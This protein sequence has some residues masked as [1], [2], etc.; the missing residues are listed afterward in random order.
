MKKTVNFLV[1]IDV[2]EDMPDWKAQNTVTLRNLEGI[3]RL[4]NFFDRYNV[5]PTYL[6]TYPVATDNNGSAVF[7]DIVSSNR[8]EIGAHM[9]T[10]TTPP[11]A[12]EEKDNLLLANCLDDETLNAKLTNIT[13]AIRDRYGFN[14]A[15]YR[16]GRFGFDYRSAFILKK[17]GYKVDTSSTPLM[18]WQYIGGPSC[19]FDS[20]KP[21]MLNEK[22]GNDEL[23]QLLE[24]PVSISLTRELPRFLKHLYLKAPAYTKIRGLL[25]SKYLNLVELIWLYPVLYSVKEMIRLTEV[26]INRD[27]FTLNMFFHSNEIKSGE[28]IYHKTD[29]HI[30]QFY[31]KL[32]CYFDYLFDSYMVNPKTLNE[33]YNDY[34]GGSL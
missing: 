2:E 16:A 1:S 3:S 27:V 34:R 6:I 31:D 11:V 33:Y 26:L 30:E 22:F 28:S 13:E 24:I 23:D 19:Y 29:A 9:H 4:Q 7:K 17:L 8:C 5:R 21:H 15:S 25:G 18:N 10:W 20:V 32:K 12:E 14:P